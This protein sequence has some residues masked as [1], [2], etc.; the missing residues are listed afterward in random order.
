MI[1]V[2][3]IIADDTVDISADHKVKTGF[4]P[5]YILAALYTASVYLFP[6]I[7][8]KV[9]LSLGNDNGLHMWPLL[10]PL[11]LGLFNLIV[12]LIGKDKISREQ[13]LNCAILIKYALVPF[14]ILGGLCIALALLF[15]L[16]EKQSPRLH[17]YSNSSSC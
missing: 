13:L 5:V 4:H 16:T 14:Y 9:N 8:F 11:I 6:F 2:E 15:M 12:I 3:D 7:Y 10:I 17:V 1:N